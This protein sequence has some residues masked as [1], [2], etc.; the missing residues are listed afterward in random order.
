MDVDVIGKQTTN[1][2]GEIRNAR[3]SFNRSLMAD[4]KSFS[5]ILADHERALNV[6]RQLADG[7]DFFKELIGL[8]GKRGY[9]R[10]RNNSVAE[11]QRLVTKAQNLEQSFEEIPITLHGISGCHTLLFLKA[12]LARFAGKDGQLELED[13]KIKPAC[14]E[15]RTKISGNISD[16]LFIPDTSAPPYPSP[17]SGHISVNMV[18][19]HFKTDAD[20]IGCQPIK[21]EYYHWDIHLK[22]CRIHKREDSDFPPDPFNINPADHDPFPTLPRGPDC[23]PKLQFPVHSLDPNDLRSIWCRCLDHKLY[24]EGKD[25]DVHKVFY[26]C[27]DGSVG[28]TLVLLPDDHPCSISTDDSC[29]DIMFRD[30]PPTTELPDD[31]EYCLGRCKKPPIVNTGL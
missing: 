29:V 27:D 9:E 18:V 24:A 23:K 15:S 2:V 7:D 30:F 4:N 10:F 14:P 31:R 5:F 21:T 28:D 12:Y 19:E 16:Y 6:I 13:G 17:G 20:L 11:L 22:S 8:E 25:V 26:W 1:L 3:G